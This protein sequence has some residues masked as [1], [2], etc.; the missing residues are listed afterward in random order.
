[1]LPTQAIEP[2][3]KG[4]IARDVWMAKII[5]ASDAQLII[6]IAGTGHVRKDVGVFQ[7]L[8]ASQQQQTFDKTKS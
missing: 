6:L 4:Q 1:M 5:N 8:T 2:M 7:W 3:V